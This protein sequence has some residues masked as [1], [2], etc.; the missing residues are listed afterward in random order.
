MNTENLSDAAVGVAAGR[1]LAILA[2]GAKE[3]NGMPVVVMPM[4]YKVEQFPLLL[5]AP[6]RKVGRMQLQDLASFAR[7][8]NTHKTERSVILVD[9]D[10]KGSRGAV[11][12]A[13][14]NYHGADPAGAD[15]GDFRAT[16]TA[17]LSVEWQRWLAKNG[18]AMEHVPFLEH[19]ENNQDLILEPKGADLLQLISA[20]EGKTDAKFSNAM[21]LHN[22]KMKLSF[23]ENVTLRA[24][25]DAATKA[26]TM[27]VP[28][29]MVVGIAPFEFGVPY[30]IRNRVR[31]RVHGRQLV[32]AYEVVD[33]HRIIQDAAS[34][35]VQKVKE[36]TEVEPF[37]GVAN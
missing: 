6:L 9:V 10:P 35:Q 34:G 25:A 32:F 20:L 1:E 22:G 24:G 11:F 30:K 17:Q 26:G 33:P 37:A 16:Y 4:D 31:Y 28:A 3:I 15:F 21:N 12:T 8:F 36:L 18:C 5:K 13:I 14:F 19:I 23:E 29:E 7:F 2:N 27:E